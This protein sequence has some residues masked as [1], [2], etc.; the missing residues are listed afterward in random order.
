MYPII[1]RLYQIDKDGY[2]RC[3]QFK[4]LFIREKNFGNLE[5]IFAQ[6]RLKSEDSR[7]YGN[8]T[9]CNVIVEEVQ[10]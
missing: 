3:I 5:L 7:Y 9:Y 4:L 6:L 2:V 10:V 1:V 8:V